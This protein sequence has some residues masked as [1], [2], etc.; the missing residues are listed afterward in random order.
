MK[1]SETCKAPPPPLVV[2]AMTV[3][4]A[5]HPK[6]HQNEIVAF[7]G[8]VHN[9]YCIDRSAPKPPYQSHF[10]A[11]AP[12]AGSIF[13]FDFRDRVKQF[14]ESSSQSQ[15]PSIEIHSSERALL[16]FILAKIHKVK[17]IFISS[18]VMMVFADIFC[19]AQET[20]RMVRGP[21]PITV[22]VV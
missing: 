7:A 6:T 18:F 1:L 2:M 5:P 9:S 13:P 10:C 4:T 3:R 8:L 15:A 20:R 12:P 21:R 17:F 16:G 22:D 11:I 19:D 14:N